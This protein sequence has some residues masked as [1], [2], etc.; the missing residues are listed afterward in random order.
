[1]SIVSL[2][3]TFAAP[4]TVLARVHTASGDMSGIDRGSIAKAFLTGTHAS[5][6]TTPGSG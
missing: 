4:D 5:S 3:G 6:M 2:P 1:M